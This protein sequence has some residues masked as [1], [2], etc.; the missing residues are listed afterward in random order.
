MKLSHWGDKQVFKRIVSKIRR[1]FKTSGIS[2]SL[3]GKTRTIYK[4]ETMLG[5]AEIP[6]A[7]SID[8]HALLSQ[9]HFCLSDASKD[10]RTKANPFVVGSPN[11]RFYCATPLMHE[12]TAIGVLAVFDAHPRTLLEELFVVLREIAFEIMLVVKEPYNT[13][14]RTRSQVPANAELAELSMKL[15]RATS[16]GTLMT[17]FEKDGSGTPYAPNS[18][19]RFSKFLKDATTSQEVEF[20]RERLALKASLA[21]TGD[22]KQAASMLAQVLCKKYN[23]DF[24]Y[25]LEIRIAELFTLPSECF[26][27][28]TS[29]IETEGFPHTNR[30]VRSR[31]DER[32]LM[33]RIIGLYG[34]DTT[35]LNLENLLH[36]KAFTSEF[37]I[38]YKDPTHSS[39][40]N[41]GI[42]MP[43]YRYN[44]KLVRKRRERE[45]EGSTIEVYLRS[46]GFL[47]GMFNVDAS[48][49]LFD[50]TMVSGVFRH[51]ALLCKLYIT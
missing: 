50:S 21:K 47:M 36:F 41:K 29:K 44:S 14:A 51:T 2:I 10:W 15:G 28:N 17:V 13:V 48:V 32:D 30:L 26:P 22:L 42:V 20:E 37:G 5:T 6:R 18:S 8:A 49:G 19:F 12:K 1:E 34:T 46:G 4:Y 7:A 9:D 24:V 35:Q 33:S 31:E 43:F 25:V 11:I 27:R 16:R 39:V 45:T 23:V 3:I 40:Y 38:S